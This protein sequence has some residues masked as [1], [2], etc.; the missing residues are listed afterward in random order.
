MDKVRTAIAK[1][2]P[3]LSGVRWSG[4][5]DGKKLGMSVSPEGGQIRQ[6]VEP[7]SS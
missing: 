1:Y 5:S 4:A 2:L 6:K 7:M 3:Q